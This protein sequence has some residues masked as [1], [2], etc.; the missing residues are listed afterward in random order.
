MRKPLKAAEPAYASR[1]R[2]CFAANYS[3]HGE[4]LS[5]KIS[6]GRRECG[7]GEEDQSEIRMQGSEDR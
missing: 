6:Y 4:R 2:F 7:E 3:A 5:D 1:R